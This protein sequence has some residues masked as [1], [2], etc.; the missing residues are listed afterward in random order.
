MVH[1]SLA[2]FYPERMV[3]GGLPIAPWIVA[4]ST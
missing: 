2:S 3:L 1:D 4:K